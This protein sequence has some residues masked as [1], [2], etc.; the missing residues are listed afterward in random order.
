ML[1]LKNTRFEASDWIGIEQMVE[2]YSI[3]WSS[4]KKKEILSCK[5]ERDFKIRQIWGGKFYFICL[6]RPEEVFN[7]LFQ[8]RYSN[9]ALYLNVSVNK[10][11]F[12]LLFSFLVYG[13]LRGTAHWWLEAGHSCS[14][15]LFI[16]C[17]SYMHFTEINI[18]EES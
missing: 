11:K 5:Q 15:V 6:C 7:Y 14:N 13:L 18:S 10:R 4:Y 12:I 2:N 1:L 3:D 17:C 8:A 16:I 9:V